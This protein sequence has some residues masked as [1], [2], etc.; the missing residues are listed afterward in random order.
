PGASSVYSIEAS[1]RHRQLDASVLVGGRREPMPGV[2]LE[3]RNQRVG[4]ALLG[5]GDDHPNAQPGPA[6]DEYVDIVDAAGKLDDDAAL[7]GAES[8][9][10]AA[11]EPEDPGREPAKLIAAILVAVSARRRIVEWRAA[12]VVRASSDHDRIG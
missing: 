3:Q 10:A 4:A 9:G 11:A 12:V 6:M 7:A 1:D 5:L 8:L 2:L